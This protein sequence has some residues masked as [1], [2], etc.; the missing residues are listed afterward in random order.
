MTWVAK[1]SK[2]GV[3]KAGVVVVRPDAGSWLS[4][5]P[6]VVRLVALSKTKFVCGFILNLYISV[7]HTNRRSIK[8]MIGVAVNCLVGMGLNIYPREAPHQTQ[9]SH[10]HIPHTLYN[11]A[12]VAECVFMSGLKILA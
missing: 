4:L 3:R 11:L 12:V 2:A 6:A 7:S 1:W 10:I 9:W 5:R 8:N